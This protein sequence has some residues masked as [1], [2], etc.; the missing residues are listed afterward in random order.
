MSDGNT[1]LQH[2][3][4]EQAADWFARRKGASGDAQL[5]ANWRQWF[6][7]S[8]VNRQAWHYVERVSE[9]FAGLHQQGP[10]AHQVLSGQRRDK[11]SRRQVLGSVGLLCGGAL[12]GWI[13]WQPALHERLA[14]LGARYR[15]SGGELRREV[16]ADG[17]Q[18]WLNGDTALDVSFDSG[19]R[20]L[21]LYAGE[22]LIETAQDPRPLRLH[23]RA[24]EL[25]P[26]GTRFSVRQQDQRTQLN[27]YQGAVQARCAESGAQ[28][29]ARAGQR[30]SFDT[31]T[32]SPL[33]IAQPQREA[34]SKGLLLA[35]DMPLGQFIEELAP[36]CR[37]HLGVSPAVS[38]LR[39]MGSFSLR[40]TAQTLAQLE[41]VL[42]VRVVRRFTWW[43]TV[44]PR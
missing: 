39:V 32:I 41:E 6:E 36:W 2:S 28:V 19:Q 8:E 44:E 4:L 23:T 1:R 10:L 35:E 38:E 43:A 18:V 14:A 27:V 22:V 25:R 29:T 26:L 33:Q 7:A 11:R 13:G 16:L 15:T 21:Q 12:L 42:P 24:G 37:G 40:D 20:L 30:L 34:W 5:E 3:H 17:T 9:R 31:R